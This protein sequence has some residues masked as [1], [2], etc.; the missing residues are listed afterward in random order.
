MQKIINK[1]TAC[2]RNVIP[3]LIALILLILVGQGFGMGL[4]PLPSPIPTPPPN[5]LTVNFLSS[6][7]TNGGD[8]MRIASNGTGVIYA[9][10]PSSGKVL[11]FMQDGTLAG[12][13]DG[14]TK[15]ISVAVDSSDRVY[16]GD[17]KDGSVSVT[18]PERKFL[19]SLGKGKGEFGMPGDIAVAAN[20]SVYVTDSKNNVVKVFASDG[21]SLFSFGGLGAANGQMNFPAGLAV[22]DINK[23]VY[24]VDQINAR[25][26]VF[27]LGGSFL[28]A[29]GSFGSGD[30][31]FTR[32]QGVYVANG[33]VFVADAFQSIV[34]VFDT[35]GNAAG[36]VG[37]PTEAQG[38]LKVP[39]DVVVSG[40]KVFVSNANDGKIKVFDLLDPQGL[41][42]TPS[43]VSFNTFANT[44]PP[45]QTVQIDAQVAGTPVAWTASVVSPF[46]IALN[47]TSGITLSTVTVSVDAT[48][49]VPG[50][51]SGMVKF[52]ANG[53]DYPLTVNLNVAAPPQQLFVAPDK[54]DLFYQQN[55]ALP[56]KALSITSS[57]GSLQW[58]AATGAPWLGVSPA[59]GTTPGA[60][61][62]SLNQNAN[63]LAE[64]IYTA[65]VSVTAPNAQGS[66]ANI[67]VTLKVVVAGTIAVTTN[68]DAATFT[69]SG[70]SPDTGSG[71]AWKTDEAKPGIYTIEFGYVKGY[72]RPAMRSFEVKTGK[73]VTVDVSYE[74]L[75]VANVVAVAK[76]AGPK[77]N[78]LVRVLDLTGNP[79]SEF[80]AFTTGTGGDTSFGAVVAMADID[81]DGTSE[82]IAAPGLGRNNQAAVKVFRYDGT[83]LSSV[84]PF[85]RTAF[86]ANIAVGDI[87][88]NGRHQV[89]MSMFKVD[90]TDEYNTV[91]IYEFSGYSLVEKSRMDI[92]NNSSY[93]ANLAFGDVDGDGK[94]ELV[95][96]KQNEI[97][98]FAF[99]E[100]LT[101]ALVASGTLSTSAAG[102]S[103]NRAPS[104]MTV[105]AGD[106]NGDGVDEIILGYVNGVD[107]FIGFYDENLKSLGTAVQVFANGQS[108]PSL[109]AMDVNGEGVAE[110]L[111]GKG[112]SPLNAATLRIYDVNGTLLREMNAFDA[113]TRYG[114]NAALGV[115][116]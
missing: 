67:P 80:R 46:P 103:R 20:G 111:A 47:L 93:P 26:E 88:G 106:I 53:V 97:N 87:L 7:P 39:M 114:V 45:A 54:I 77:N 62:V 50:S 85:D 49:I 32:P 35:A 38:N 42:I 83:L 107:S 75:A 113:S 61:N 81:G 5:P 78:A 116:K 91:V 63:S 60:V 108:A 57:G 22:D 98:I 96:S 15:P 66:P 86:G 58:T 109:S 36:Y 19:F 27:S 17:N 100:S 68:L 16:V 56:E 102:T 104:L 21:T 95:V 90:K 29:F 52:N 2:S 30:T 10:V 14:F 34:K 11:K 13:I 101:P 105:S 31:Q 37:W 44:N 99:N 18:S 59:S 3:F 24:V 48:G 28:R 72:R 65:T 41:V 70:P 23:E 82:I 84:G 6:I 110:I 92:V 55:G 51:Y 76:G 33:K 79:I 1:K 74:P 25:V 4:G 71:K 8:P 69:I 12:S 94:L 9:A 89:A 73:S 43:T 40:T 112:P 64:G 115:K